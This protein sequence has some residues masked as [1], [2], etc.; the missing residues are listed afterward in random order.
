MYWNGSVI[1][2]WG[3]DGNWDGGVTPGVNR[4]V[5]IQSGKPSYPTVFTSI[6]VKSLELRPGATVTI[7]NNAV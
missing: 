2:V 5:I 6:E 4:V 1:N 7:Y 3:N